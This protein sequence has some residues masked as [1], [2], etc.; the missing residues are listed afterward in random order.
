MDQPTA[1]EALKR[2]ESYLAGCVSI[3]EY[4]RRA[5]GCLDFSITP[6]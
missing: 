6:T 2:L 3:V 1:Q 4:G 5:A